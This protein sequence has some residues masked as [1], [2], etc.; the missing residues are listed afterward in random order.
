MGHTSWA[1]S[2]CSATGTSAAAV[3]AVVIEV[4]EEYVSPSSVLPPAPASSPSTSDDSPLT[5]IHEP[6]E[7]ATRKTTAA[8]KAVMTIRR[9]RALRFMETPLRV[10]LLRNDAEVEAED[11][12]EGVGEGC[13]TEECSEEG[14]S[15]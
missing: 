6:V 4:G 14:R 10:G 1:S 3:A 2:S 13:S 11:R 12:R 7:S 9:S 5:E 15:W 8:P